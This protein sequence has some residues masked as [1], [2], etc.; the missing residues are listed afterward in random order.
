MFVGLS[1]QLLLDF[2]SLPLGPL[3]SSL[4]A[5]ES[6]VLQCQRGDCWRQVHSRKTP[7]PKRWKIL[8]DRQ[9]E[10]CNSISIY[11]HLKQQKY[12][13]NESRMVD[14]WYRYVSLC[15]K[16]NLQHFS[17][18]LSVGSACSRADSNYCMIHQFS[19]FVDQ[20]KGVAV[21]LAI[22]KD[23][24]SWRFRQRPRRRQGERFRQGWQHSFGGFHKW[25]YP[26]LVGFP[27]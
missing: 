12:R 15:F 26:I 11:Q 9:G 5:E 20:E 2:P 13:R 10:I 22:C 14:V 16:C 23:A 18:L 4:L 7:T 21:E 17:N 19:A 24:I 8:V 25:R 1:I 6:L 3:G 27:L